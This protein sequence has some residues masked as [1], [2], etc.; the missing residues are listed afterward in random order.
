MASNRQKVKCFGKLRWYR[1]CNMIEK[2]HILEKAT[3]QK[4][5]IL[6]YSFAQFDMWSA[7]SIA[8]LIKATL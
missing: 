5:Q 6:G 1:K 3:A 7:M 4:W 8:T 2:L